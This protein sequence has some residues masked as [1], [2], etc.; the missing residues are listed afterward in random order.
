M[1]NILALGTLL[2]VPAFAMGGQMLLTVAG[3]DTAVVAPGQSVVVQV[4]FDSVDKLVA[5]YECTFNVVDGTGADLT[6][7]NWAFAPAFSFNNNSA[8]GSLAAGTPIVTGLSFTNLGPG[9]VPF[10]SFTLTL[11]AA[12]GDYPYVITT[13][14]VLVSDELAQ[15]I[16]V[17]L[18][19]LTLTPEP[20]SLLL[21]GLGGLMLRRRR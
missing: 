16:P 3:S 19:Q 4:A 10:G 15:S 9:I 6:I 21:L 14:H 12:A 1:K 8:D 20:V 18:G 7:S 2:L 5:G 17:T 11:G 13:N